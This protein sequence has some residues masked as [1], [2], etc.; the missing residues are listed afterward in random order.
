MA[1]EQF[2]YLYDRLMEDMP[3]GEWLH[4]AGQCWDKYGKPRRIV[5]LGCGTGSMAVPLARQ[6]FEVYGIDLSDDMLAVAQ[7]KADEEQRR[8]AFAPGGSV[9]WLQQDMREWEIG[10]PADAVLSFCDCVNYLLEEEDVLSSFRSAY[11]GLKPG[12]IFVFD[13]HTPYQL[14]A[15]AKTQPFFLNEDDIAYIW[16]SDYDPSRVEIEHSLTIF[17][18]EGAYDETGSDDALTERFHRVE[19]LHVQRAYALDWIERAL[20]EAGFRETE[21]YADF[22]WKRPT[23]ET[24]RAFFVAVK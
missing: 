10:R 14:E 16:T 19:E 8:S 23:A 9:T 3:Y 24:Q 17:V 6:G 22:L 18:K 7:H 15:Y 2:A 21:V 20:K 11:A 1:Y 12:G 4:F 13:V 5:D